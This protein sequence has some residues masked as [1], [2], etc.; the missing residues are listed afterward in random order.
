ML[1][2]SQIS[3]TRP[4]GQDEDVPDIFYEPES[5]MTPE[6]MKEADPLGEQ[7]LLDQAMKELAET[8]WPTPISALKEVVILVAVIAGTAA[9]IIGWD[10]LLRDFYTNV[11]LIPGP[12]DLKTGA[13]NMVLPDGWTDGMS[14][15]DFM[16]FQD[17]V[18]KAATAVKDAAFP[19][20]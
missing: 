6:E 15:D 14:E 16:K 5:E 8:I 2:L 3:Q 1:D 18:G 10:N 9:L 7:P 4:R 20:L 12:E 17:E 13:E 11:G 19:D